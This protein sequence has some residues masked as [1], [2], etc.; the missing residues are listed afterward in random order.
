MGECAGS[1]DSSDATVTL[2]R[3]KEAMTQL[4]ADYTWPWYETN[5][6]LLRTLYNIHIVN[7]ISI[8]AKQQER[9]E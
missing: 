7:D 1:T 3:V 5:K 6:Q 4:L 2:E 8:I 9:R